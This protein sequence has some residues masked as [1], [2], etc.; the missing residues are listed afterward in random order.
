MTTGPNQAIDL[1]SVD[2]VLKTTRSVRQRLDLERPVPRA[3]IR[4]AI[5]V[6]LQAPTGGNTRT[7]RFLV[8]TDAETR[9]RIADYYRLG[10]QAYV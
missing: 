2:H 7:W 6:A 8:V 1:A 9:A 10:A 3:L 5:E 4:E